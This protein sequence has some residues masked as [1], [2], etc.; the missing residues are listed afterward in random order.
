MPVPPASADPEPRGAAPRGTGGPSITTEPEDA[1]A[2][3]WR[4]RRPRS[5]VLGLLLAALAL[6]V[7]LVTAVVVTLTGGPD[8]ARLANHNPVTTANVEAHRRTGGSVSWTPVPYDQIAPEIV[9]AVVVGEDI[10]FYTHHGFSPGEIRS[11]LEE[12]VFEGKRLRG[13]STI[14]QQL[15]RYLWLSRERSATR[16]VTEAWLTWRL[17]HTLS[18]RR[19]LELYLNV[20]E[21]YPGVF[22]VEAASRRFFDKSA[23]ELD[24][25]QAAALAASL[26]AAAW[27]PG[28]DR[29]NYLAHVKRIRRRMDEA[30]WLRDKI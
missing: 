5:L 6:L 13:A 20:A 3:H 30:T 27:R 1:S 14:T 21:F 15:A 4:W 8:I 10:S 18:K 16:K 28:S 24:A 11:A 17:E 23:S 26:P 9:L 19:I 12:T 7:L 22:G 29:E 25:D 2:R